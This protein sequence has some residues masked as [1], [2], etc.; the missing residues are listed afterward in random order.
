M[1]LLVFEFGPNQEG[2][3][4]GIVRNDSSS[5]V[6]DHTTDGFVVDSLSLFKMGH[7]NN[8]P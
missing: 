6:G 3:S 8:N 4:S 7:F 1:L 5:Q 2:A